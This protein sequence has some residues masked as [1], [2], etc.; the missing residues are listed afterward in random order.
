MMRGI[1]DNSIDLIYLDPPFNSNANYAAPIGSKSAG[2]EF[3][4]TWT[5]R[6]V[7]DAWWGEIAEVY[8]G[9]YKILDGARLVGGSS[10]KSYLIY[11]AIRIIEMH[12]IL[13]PTGSLYLHCDTTMSHYLKLIL[14]S[15]FGSKS[16]RNDITWKRFSSHNDGNRYGK[17]SDQILFYTKDPKKYTWNKMYM[18]YDENYLENEFKSKDDRGFYMHKALTAEGLTG[19]GYTYEFAGHTR[20]WKRSLESMLDLEARGLVHYPKKAGG[21]PRYKIYKPGTSGVPKENIAKGLPIQNIWTDIPN[22]QG[23]EDLDYPTQKPLKLLERIIEASSNEGEIIFDPFCGCATACHAAARLNRKWIGIDISSKAAELIDRRLRGDIQVAFEGVIHRTDIPKQAPQKTKCL[24]N[25]LYGKQEGECNGCWHHFHIR[26]L[27]EDHIIPQSKGGQ[28]D[29]DNFQL[30]CGN[31]NSIK[32]DRD[33]SYL[34][35]KLKKDGLRKDSCHDR[36]P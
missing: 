13:K 22:V 25:I 20:V 30:L 3:K 14:D 11:M 6:D 9:L 18:P 16:Y 2:A 17:I 28:D 31:C 29:D 8:E 5:L 35:A 23:K 33:M 15:I 24:K 1:R 21:V 12:R 32:G 7:D 36:H 4:D 10:V 34:I 27:T 26:H 19:G